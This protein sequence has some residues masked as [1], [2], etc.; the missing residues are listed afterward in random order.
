[1]RSL[2]FSCFIV[3]LSTFANITHASNGIERRISG[4]WSS[5]PEGYSRSYYGLSDAKDVFMF[6]KRDLKVEEGT[7]SRR[8]N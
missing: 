7:E 2:K 6:L 4:G 8:G 5:T 3:G 1:M